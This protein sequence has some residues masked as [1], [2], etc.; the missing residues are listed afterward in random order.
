MAMTRAES[1]LG[2]TA[3]GTSRARRVGMILLALLAV[4]I[5]L[6]ASWAI[7]KLATSGKVNPQGTAVT[8]PGG[9][10]TVESVEHALPAELGAALPAGTHVVAVTLVLVADDS[11]TLPI[12]IA[13]YAIEGTGID[14]I[15]VPSTTTPQLTSVP[16][17]ATV[18]TTAMYAVPDESTELVLDLPG[19]AKVSA[20]HA[21]HPGDAIR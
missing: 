15:V 1:E 16:G 10:V 5:L 17:G 11:D 2:A 7:M 13:D 21:D 6:E 4:V 18:T 9:H 20:E 19:G 14:G 3:G 12:N 8:I